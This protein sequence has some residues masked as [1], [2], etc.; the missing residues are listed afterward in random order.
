MSLDKNPPRGRLVVGA[1][2]RVSGPGI[3]KSSSLFPLPAPQSTA[4][5][6]PKSA[7]GLSDTAMKSQMRIS[8]HQNPFPHRRIPK[9]FCLQT[10]S[11]S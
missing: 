10:S 7:L 2:R 8:F 9:K 6:C 1:R 11:A 3:Q 4:T 5:D